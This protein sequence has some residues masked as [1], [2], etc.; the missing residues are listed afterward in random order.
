MENLG[1]EAD[2]LLLHELTGM[3][4]EHTFD[5][6]SLLGVVAYLFY[7]PDPYHGSLSRLL[8]KPNHYADR[9][10]DTRLGNMNEVTEH[11]C[12]RR[13]RDLSCSRRKPRA[14]S[15]HFQ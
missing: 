10:V 11:C 6:P 3:R 15:P 2:C 4:P 7:L 13:V 1:E 14:P 9:L 8:C 12:G 5:R